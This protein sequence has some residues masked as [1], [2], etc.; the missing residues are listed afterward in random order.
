MQMSDEDNSRMKAPHLQLLYGARA[1]DSVDKA[2]TVASFTVKYE[3]SGAVLNEFWRAWEICM[4]VFVSMGGACAMLCWHKWSV[5]SVFLHRNTCSMSECFGQRG[6]VHLAYSTTHAYPSAMYHGAVINRHSEQ[7]HSRDAFC[8]T[9]S[10][11]VQQRRAG[12]TESEEFASLINFLGDLAY[13]AGL[14]LAAAALVLAAHS[15]VVFKGQAATFLYTISNEDLGRLRAT[16]IAAACVLGWAVCHMIYRQTFTTD[17][18]LVDWE[19]P[20]QVCASCAVGLKCWT[21]VKPAQA[22]AFHA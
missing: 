16:I 20:Q 10:A 21:K 1:I 2:T 7:E 22:P 15:F 4:G 6:A 18:A 19:R 5:R 3:N 11:H 17:I 13:C 8:F 12:F 9:W 14:G